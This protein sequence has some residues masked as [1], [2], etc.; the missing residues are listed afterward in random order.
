MIEMVKQPYH[1]HW[2]R[3]WWQTVWTKWD[4][5][6]DLRN[7]VVSRLLRARSLKV[8]TGLKPRQH[9]VEGLAALLNADP[10]DAAPRLWLNSGSL[11]QV[12]AEVL[13][14]TPLLILAPGAHGF[15][16]R[17]PSARYAELAVRLLGPDGVM[18]GGKLAVLGGPGE[19]RE[20]APVIAAL[21]ADRVIDLVG[22]TGLLLAAAWLARADLYIGN[23]SGL[24]HLAA[25]AGAPTLALFG[26]G[27]PAR[28][29][30]WGTAATYL[31]AQDDPNRSIDMCKIDDHLALAEMEKLSVDQVVAA[32][33]SLYVVEHAA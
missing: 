3:L 17:W 4:L 27:L 21:P 28:Y 16:K 7:S 5:I 1:G 23:D 25:A 33:Q 18:A 20:A 19:H 31:I 32:A 10:K 22:Q 6:V 14:Q 2:R 29:R 12:A 13:R 8:F 9:M 26:P 11:E 30:P 15:G 24:T